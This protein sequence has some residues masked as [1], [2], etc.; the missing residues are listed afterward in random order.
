MMLIAKEQIVQTG[1]HHPCTYLRPRPLPPKKKQLYVFMTVKE[2]RPKLAHC[3]QVLIHSK[4]GENNQLF[5]YLNKYNNC[6]R[7]RDL[8]DI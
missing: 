7:A 8:H 1:T 2:G 3:N 5:F 4:V 6:H